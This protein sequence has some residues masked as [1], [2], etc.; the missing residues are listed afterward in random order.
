MIQIENISIILKMFFV[1]IYSQSS[2]PTQASGNHWSAVSIDL[3]LL[4]I[5]INGIMPYVG[6]CVSLGSLTE[7]FWG[8]S[9]M[10]HVSVLGFHRWTVFQRTVMSGLSVHSLVH[11]HL[12]WFHFLVVV[13][14]ASLNIS[15]KSLYGDNIFICFE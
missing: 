11:R 4:E 1:P 6:L 8:W 12:H 15:Y 7:C 14:N 3:P 9:M 5:Y 13:T 10:L 2:L